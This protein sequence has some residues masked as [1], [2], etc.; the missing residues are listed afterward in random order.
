M[1]TGP[2]CWE[3]VRLATL[4]VLLAISAAAEH[5]HT[6]TGSCEDAEPPIVISAGER[7]ELPVTERLDVRGRTIKLRAVHEELQLTYVHGLADASEIEALVSMAESRAGW[8]RSPL[9]KQSSGAR[10]DGDAR[11]N[12]SSCPMLWP[13][14]YG[15]RRE[16][17]AQRP[18]LLAELELVGELS[19]RV[20]ALFSASGVPV[21]PQHIEP[22]QL[23]RY[24]PSEHFGPH[25]DYHASAESSVQG[26]QR[27]F[28][29]LL[30]G[31]TLGEGDGGETHFPRLDVYVSPRAGDA[32][33]W[34]NVDAEGEPNERS[35]HEGRPPKGGEKLAINV[36]VADRPFEVSSGGGQG[37]KRAVVT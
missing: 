34:A 28:T 2:S 30:F 14:V 19:A 4:A 1:S 11:R 8:M 31:S 9:K 6:A 32:L 29:L 13:L 7:V 10:A 3:P 37:L 16:D 25:H 33:I 26:E 15:S 24:Q 36:W 22:L 35:L 23:V 18:E 12:S 20:A 5:S 17:F 21:T 27:S